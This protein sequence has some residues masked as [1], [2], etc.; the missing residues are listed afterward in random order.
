MGHHDQNV[1]CLSWHPN[2]NYIFT[3]SNDKTVRM[4]DVQSGQSVRILSGCKFGIN[5][6][7]VSPSG[8]YVA[9]ADYSGTVSIWDLRNGRKLNEFR[10]IN[11]ETGFSPIIHSM[12]Y[13]PCGSTIATGGEDCSIRLWDARGLGN[14]KSNPEY[15]ALLGREQSST[16]LYSALASDSTNIQSKPGNRDPIKTF[17]TSDSIILDLEFTKRNL[18]LSV[19]KYNPKWCTTL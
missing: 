3:G 14:H 12:S 17:F 2:C 19:G 5:Q 1:N 13:S 7:K 15:A 11:K 4:W 16:H 10:H 6:V 9:G 18:L 8:Q